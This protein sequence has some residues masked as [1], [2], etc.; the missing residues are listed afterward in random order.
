MS[1]AP[2]PPDAPPGSR[3]PVTIPRLAELKAQGQ[4]I[5]MVT[6]YD[7]PSAQVAEEAEVDVV[8]VGDTA[9]MTVLGYDSTVPV[10][11]PAATP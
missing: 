3:E 9:A 10:S 4:P 5:V 7:F 2:R 6:A 8:L 11:M 1:T